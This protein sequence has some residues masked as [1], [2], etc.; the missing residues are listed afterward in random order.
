M[1]PI[2]LR[3]PRA[4][5][6]EF[7]AATYP[8]FRTQTRVAMFAGFVNLV[9][10]GL[11]F[12]LL[13]PEADGGAVIGRTFLLSSIPA[14]AGFA[15]A[16]MP[17][18]ERLRGIQV[19]LSVLLTGV[20]LSGIA[21]IVPSV[22]GGTVT[23]VSITVT[24]LFGLVFMGAGQLVVVAPAALIV[25]AAALVT[26]GVGAPD[27]AHR[28]AYWLGIVSTV[29]GSIGAAYFVEMYVRRDFM[30]QREL[31]EERRTSE[32]LLLNVLPAPIAVR[33]KA[34]EEPIADRHA[35]ATVLFADIVGF[36]I[37]SSK[38]SPDEM[39]ELLNSV[40]T[41]FDQM[42][43]RHGLEKIKTIGD[44]YMA[45][46]GLPTRRDDHAEAC[47]NLALEMQSA[48]EGRVAPSGD[49]LQVRIGINTGPVVAGV[50]G[51]S[52]FAYDLWGDAVNT[53]SRMESHG[54]PAGIQV[55]ESTYR[56]LRG[57]YRFEERG[58]VDVKGKGLMPTWLLTGREAAV[59]EE[60]LAGHEVAR[61]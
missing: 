52:K 12:G 7:N 16:F 28:S 47:A 22:I 15:M 58:E 17:G 55:T 50:I 24:L 21:L 6:A 45:V 3:F 25:A 31:E 44:A 30:H 26:T 34:G 35:E 13:V 40:F 4:L 37:I 43:A 2:T 1:H 19:A 53:A 41:E 8:R 36:T 14:L 51:S 5:E 27:W 61:G 33:L 18:Y 48:L 38:V 11:W 54:V 23:T 9:A 59:H 60:D 46:G 49:P 29:A 57:K 20:A 39:V 32:R 56:R 10:V 42:A